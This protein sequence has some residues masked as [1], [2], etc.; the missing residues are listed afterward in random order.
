MK[1]QATE[2]RA[3]RLSRR[4]LGEHCPR[5]TERSRR[6]NTGEKNENTGFDKNEVNVKS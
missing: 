1:V 6:V 4:R 3:E 2:T 5:D